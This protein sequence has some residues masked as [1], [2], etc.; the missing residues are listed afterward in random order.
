MSEFD[1][2]KNVPCSPE[3]V[4][5]PTP[6]QCRTARARLRW[7]ADKLA[8]VANIGRTTVFRY[9]RGQLRPYADTLHAIRIAFETEDIKFEHH[10]GESWVGFPD[11]LE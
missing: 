5:L 11:P 9:E 3:N 6:H 10:D 7:S 4:P 8:E 2:T 1:A